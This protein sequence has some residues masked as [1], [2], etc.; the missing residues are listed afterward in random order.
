MCVKIFH[1]PVECPFPRTKLNIF[2]F[3]DLAPTTV[4]I[5]ELGRMGRPRFIQ[6]SLCYLFTVQLN[7]QRGDRVCT[8]ADLGFNVQAPH[9]AC[10][11]LC[12][13][14]SYSQYYLFMVVIRKLWVWPNYII[15]CIICGLRQ[16]LVWEWAIIQWN[17]KVNF[18]I[19]IILMV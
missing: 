9:V 10:T 18:S 14:V 7:L 17:W 12:C 19:Q 15:T 16:F 3:Y 2:C 1:I 4:S 5:K 6:F 8:C 11:S 13:T